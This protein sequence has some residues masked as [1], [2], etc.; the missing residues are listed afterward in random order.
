MKVLSR[1]DAVR[2]Y[3]CIY[4]RPHGEMRYYVCLRTGEEIALKTCAACAMREEPRLHLRVES[5]K[6]PKNTV[7]IALRGERCRE[8]VAA[9][10]GISVSALTAYE[11]GTRTPRDKIKCALARYYGKSVGGIFFAKQT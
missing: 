5:Q 8:I 10:V 2:K 3:K 4:A 11:L 7:L 1:H 6:T 9:A